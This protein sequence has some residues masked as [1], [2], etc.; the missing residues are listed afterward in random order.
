MPNQI[1]TPEH[2]SI[3]D[4]FVRDIKYIIPAYQRPYS[5]E[6]IG[7]N[8]ANSQINNMWDDFYAFY[9]E[10]NEDKEYFFGSIVVYK[11][12]EGFQVVDGQQRLT[13]LLLFFAA[14]KCFLKDSEAIV[15]QESKDALINFIQEAIQTIDDTLYNKE[16]LSLTSTL[17]VKIQRIGSQNFDDI[18]Q[19]S[20]KCDDKNA[21]LPEKNLKIKPLR[22]DIL[23]IETF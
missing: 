9:Q 17:K 7:K 6:S 11:E 21:I 14:M 2:K 8:D 18:L 16:T 5:W 20:V 19:K 4:I 10:N 15:E 1:F 23:I 12:K 3:N 13:S 22:S